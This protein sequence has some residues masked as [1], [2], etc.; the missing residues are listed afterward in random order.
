PAL[1]EAILQ[2]NTDDRK[3]ILL[4]FFEQQDFRSVG[5]ALGSNEDAARMRVT[6]ALEKLHSLLKHRGVTLSATAL[7]ATLAAEAVTAAPAGLAVA[8]SSAAVT[9]AVAGTG[10]KLTFLKI[11]AMTKLK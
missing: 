9:A 6:R 3:A 2:L 5:E 1:D 7:G 10:T 8:V 4:R 11:M